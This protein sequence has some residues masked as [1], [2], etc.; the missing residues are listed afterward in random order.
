MS[1][2]IFKSL[3]D[4]LQILRRRGSSST[5]ANLYKTLPGFILLCKDQTTGEEFVKTHKLKRSN[6]RLL[7]TSANAPDDML[8]H[9]DFPLAVD[10]NALMSITELA[11]STIQR[12]EAKIHH[13]EQRIGYFDILI[14]QLGS[15]LKKYWPDHY[16]ERKWGH[17]FNQN[18]EYMRI[19][20]MATRAWNWE[21]KKYRRACH[22]NNAIKYNRIHLRNVLAKSTRGIRHF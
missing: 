5:V 15:M 1:L 16:A 20:S 22:K 13:L 6:I 21:C 7:S 2:Q 19:L 17:H 11:I 18:D 4:N 12:Y 3:Q 10:N 9:N 8:R 14:G